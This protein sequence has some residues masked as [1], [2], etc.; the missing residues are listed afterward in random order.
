MSKIKRNDLY[1]VRE[2][3]PSQSN[4]HEK[5]RSLILASPLLKNLKAFQEVNARYIDESYEPHNHHYDFYIESLDTIIE[6]HGE[7]HY[8]FTNRG[9]VQYEEALSE[10]NSSKVRDRQKKELAI[11][12][13]LTY[14]EIP[15][16]LMNKL[17]VEQLHEL[18]LKK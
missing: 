4:F 5:I 2:T 15:Y 1:S 9:N 10:W 17:T 8:K 13:G 6:C 7:Q 14:V 12:K 11:S 3:L 18:I 16:S